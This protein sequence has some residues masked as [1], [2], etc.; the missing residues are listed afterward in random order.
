MAALCEILFAVCVSACLDLV[1]ACVC[2]V[3]TAVYGSQTAEL[4]WVGVGALQS[5]S[6]ESG[7]SVGDQLVR[8]LP[9]LP[10]TLSSP[11]WGEL[12]SVDLFKSWTT[13]GPTFDRGTLKSGRK[14]PSVLG[15]EGSEIEAHGELNLPL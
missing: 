4:W 9:A 1:S 11:P 15:E 14:E 8:S 12:Q 5:S 3:D 7:Q 13:A 2:A 6:A 10:A